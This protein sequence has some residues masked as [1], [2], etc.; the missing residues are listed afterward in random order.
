MERTA[1]E[2]VAIAARLCRLD[3]F[4]MRSD[5]EVRDG[6]LPRRLAHGAKLSLRGSVVTR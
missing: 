4:S 3:V 5:I 2:G 1:V 6:G